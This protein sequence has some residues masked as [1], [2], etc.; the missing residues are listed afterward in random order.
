MHW[1]GKMLFTF[2][3]AFVRYERE[4]VAALNTFI[5]QCSTS[6]QL[7]IQKK[8][9]AHLVSKICL[10]PTIWGT[11]QNISIK[12]KK[13]PYFILRSALEIYG[14][15]LMKVTLKTYILR[16]K[17][18]GTWFLSQ[19]RY[20]DSFKSL[21][22]CYH[23]SSVL[24]TVHL[25]S[26]LKAKEKFLEKNATELLTQ[27]AS[28]DTIKTELNKNFPVTSNFASVELAS[29]KLL[30]YQVSTETYSPS[31]NP[32]L[33]GQCGSEYSVNLDINNS[34]SV[35]LGAYIS[36]MSFKFQQRSEHDS[37]FNAISGMLFKSQ[38]S[39]K[40]INQASVDKIVGIIEPNNLV[41]ET[42]VDSLQCQV[43]YLESKTEE[44]QLHITSL[45]QSRSNVNFKVKRGGNLFVDNESVND[46][47]DSEESLLGSIILEIGIEEITID[48][49]HE[50]R[51]S[52]KYYDRKKFSNESIR[53]NKR[54]YSAIEIESTVKEEK[55]KYDGVSFFKSSYR[56]FSN[57]DSTISSNEHVHRQFQTKRKGYVA[58]DIDSGEMADASDNDENDEKSSLLNEKNCPES[59]V[60]LENVD[61][62]NVEV[63]SSP[64]TQIVTGWEIAVS[65]IAKTALKKVWTSVAAPLHLRT[66]H[67]ENDQDVN[68][69]AV[70][71]PALGCWV[72]SLI[73]TASTIASVTEI[74]KRW[75]SSVF[76]SLMGQALPEQGRLLK[77]HITSSAS[78][79]QSRFLQE[80]CS[81][82]LVCLLRRQ[83]YGHRLN[84]LKISLQKNTF[85]PPLDDLEKGIHALIRQWKCIIIGVEADNAALT[86][87]FVGYKK[88]VVGRGVLTQKD[89]EILMKDSETKGSGG[90]FSRRLTSPGN[91]ISKLE[92]VSPHRVEYHKG[93]ANVEVESATESEGSGNENVSSPRRSNKT[94]SPRNEE[95]LYDWMSKSPVNSNHISSPIK[96]LNLD[97]I[98][99]NIDEGSHVDYP[100]SYR[101]LRST[102]PMVSVPTSGMQ[103]ADAAEVFSPLLDILNIKFPKNKLGNNLTFNKNIKVGDFTMNVI[104]TETDESLKKSQTKVT[105]PAL[106]LEN[107]TSVIQMNMMNEQGL[108]PEKPTQEVILQSY[109]H[110]THFHINFALVRLILQT[111]ET[112]KVVREQKQYAEK[113]SRSRN[114][115]HPFQWEYLYTA[116]SDPAV[117]IPKCWRNMYNVMTL[118]ELLPKSK[119]DLPQEMGSP[120]CKYFRC[121]I[122]KN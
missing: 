101:S 81:S 42:T 112:F 79:S 65:V 46:G 78:T 18:V 96:S 95:S 73:S 106:S 50:K 28:W 24:D 108:K 3:G 89:F 74:S 77:K 92:I 57:S 104:A 38:Q 35:L 80:E 70:L 66:H 12:L 67:S 55:D 100:M 109:L 91:P 29:L 58:L 62:S 40:S 6:K 33:S 111:H 120:S 49:S 88:P 102:T 54:D 34:D 75:K 60:A 51:V 10:N 107:F 36:D 47:I 44:K 8:K 71:V 69:V 52:P 87:A 26:I 21:S 5:R 99:S 64:I 94:K 90:S 68:L 82:Q 19:F 53:S 63:K 98:E 2:C 25:H 43:L 103:L 56:Q 121:F 16:V 23:L 115:T 113:S 32:S 105:I 13:F 30:F 22:A 114:T 7:K 17:I 85:I 11:K 93:T 118:Y 61:H 39:Q 76:A 37:L 86:S 9:I 48:G 116:L 119:S 41:C 27:T 83:T 15:F 14:D 31:E 4:M 1:R 117:D 45:P 122:F 59:K 110:E 97:Q 84:N 20:I 72:P